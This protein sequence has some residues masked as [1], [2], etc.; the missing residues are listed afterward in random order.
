MNQTAKL[1]S[2]VVQPPAT[3]AMRGQGLLQAIV[4]SPITL[5]LPVILGLFGLG[6]SLV[7][8]WEATLASESP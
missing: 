2:N 1:G 8:D 4:K 7:Q 6:P 3:Q 5:P